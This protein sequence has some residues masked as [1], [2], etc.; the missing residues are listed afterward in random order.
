M[1]KKALL[2]LFSACAAQKTDVVDD[3]ERAILE[4]T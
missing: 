1:I 3:L 4:E 2:I